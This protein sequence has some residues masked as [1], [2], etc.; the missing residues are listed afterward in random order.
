MTPSNLDVIYHDSEHSAWI[1]GVIP[2]HTSTEALSE[3]TSQILSNCATRAPGWTYHCTIW[4]SVMPSKLGQCLQLQ[5]SR[6]LTF[7]NIRK[8]K[9]LHYPKPP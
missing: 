4:T 7:S 2:A 1:K 3:T 6:E 5:P 8:Q 9:W